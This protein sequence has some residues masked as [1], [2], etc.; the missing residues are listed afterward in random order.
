MRTFNI[1]AKSNGLV[2]IKYDYWFGVTEDEFSVKVKNK[3]NANIIVM[4]FVGK[5]YN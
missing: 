4:I 1:W 3:Y 2:T 5:L